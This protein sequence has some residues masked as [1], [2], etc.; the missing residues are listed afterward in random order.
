V[1]KWTL[2]FRSRAIL[3]FLVVL[4]L[5][6][7]TYEVQYARPDRMILDAVLHFGGFAFL[8]GLFFALALPARKSNVVMRRD[9][10][11]KRWTSSFRSRAILAF[12]FGLC[13]SLVSYGVQFTRPRTIR[14]ALMHFGS[15]VL[16]Y[17]VF[18]ALALLKRRRR[19]YPD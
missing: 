17:G 11:A 7:V 1:K 13:L 3:A 6:L 14:H 9:Q 12:L 19:V 18:L 2:S 16:F 10:P 4:C 15:F 5:S 8:Y